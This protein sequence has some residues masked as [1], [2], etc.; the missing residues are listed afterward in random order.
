MH[1]S[2]EEHVRCSATL[3][4][5]GLL[6]AGCVTLQEH[7]TNHRICRPTFPQTKPYHQTFDNSQAATE[8]EW[9]VDVDSIFDRC[10]AANS[11]IPDG[12]RMH[13]GQIC[14]RAKALNSEQGL[15]T[16]SP[17]P[18]D[19]FTPTPVYSLEWT[20]SGGGSIR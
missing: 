8:P 2:E 18:N 14:I 13:S 4:D 1:R 7:V 16:L 9:T 12:L 6:V 20:P 19:A 5:R 3:G 11:D 17:T 10:G 15:N